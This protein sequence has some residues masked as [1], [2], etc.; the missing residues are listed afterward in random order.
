[1]VQLPVPGHLTLNWVRLRQWPNVLTV[2][3]GGGCLDMFSLALWGTARYGLKYCLR[4][5]LNPN[6]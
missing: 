1:M 4:G 6:Q 2:G 5:P 3:I